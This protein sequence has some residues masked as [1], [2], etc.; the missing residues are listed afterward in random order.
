MPLAFA[1]LASGVSFLIGDEGIAHPLLE[2]LGIHYFQF[3]CKDNQSL[4]K[5]SRV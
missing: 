3:R 1:S 4:L 5:M 2:I